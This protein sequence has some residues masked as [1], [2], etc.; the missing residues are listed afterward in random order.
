M[1]LMKEPIIEC[2]EVSF[3]FDGHV[4]VENVSLAINRGDYVGLIGP[5]GAGK[6]TLIKVFLGLLKPTSGTVNLFGHDIKHFHDWHRIG[7]VPQKA[8]SF[9]PAFP[10]TV[11]EVV[12]M[13]RVPVIG[14]GRRFTPADHAAVKKAMIIV[15]IDNLAGKR[16]GELSGGQQQRVF[17]ARAL[18]SEP[19]ML[20]LDE[21][22]TGVD[23]R[24]QHEFYHF[25]HGL[26]SQEHMT[27]ILISHDTSMVNLHISKLLCLNRTLMDKGCNVEF[28]EHPHEHAGRH[29]H[30]RETTHP[31]M[32]EVHH[33]H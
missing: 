29:M 15:G 28:L 31:L 9:D 14:L 7:Y 25:L 26:N 13:G 19:E 6:T 8:T 16:I 5:N 27:L 21:P 2:K 11:E 10:V 30:D 17:I 32:K 12:A 3:A 4:V 24:S 33:R 20:I 18:A 23:A 22:T 1:P